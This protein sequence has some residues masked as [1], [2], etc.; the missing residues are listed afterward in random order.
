MAME[1]RARRRTI[2]MQAMD[3]S[4]MPMNGPKR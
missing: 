4:K 3:M 2:G 1:V